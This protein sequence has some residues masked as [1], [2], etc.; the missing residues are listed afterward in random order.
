M[1]I[2][3][4]I[5]LCPKSTQNEEPVITATLFWRVLVTRSTSDLANV[6]K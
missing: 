6:K 2:M 1:G 3:I 5:W 4:G